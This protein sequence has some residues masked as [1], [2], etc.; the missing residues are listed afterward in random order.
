MGKIHVKVTELDGETLRSVPEYEDV[1]AVAAHH[2]IPM[3]E[4]RNLIL[5]EIL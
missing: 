1:K 3:W 5:R 2:N 4:A